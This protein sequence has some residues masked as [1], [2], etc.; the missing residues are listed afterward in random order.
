MTITANTLLSR[1]KYGYNGSYDVAMKGLSVVVF[2]TWGC[3]I[4]L[5]R[6]LT[7]EATIRHLLGLENLTGIV[8]DPVCGEIYVLYRTAH[9][10][11]LYRYNVDVD[12]DVV[13]FAMIHYF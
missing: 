12:E 8:E 6:W 13:M 3:S 2:A 4:H 11:V 9:E 5:D 1:P 10:A 7:V